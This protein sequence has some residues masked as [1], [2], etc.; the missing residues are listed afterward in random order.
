MHDLI[1]GLTHMGSFLLGAWVYSRARTGQPVIPA[2]PW[3]RK[4]DA[5]DDEQPEKKWVKL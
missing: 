3:K 5:D 4:P 1:L 2:I